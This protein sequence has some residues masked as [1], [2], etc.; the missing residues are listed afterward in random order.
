MKKQFS[1]LFGAFALT[2]ALI[3]NVEAKTTEAAKKANAKTITIGTTAGDFSELANVGLKPQLEKQGYTVKVVE[4]TDYE[5]PNIA[6][7][8]GKIDVN[9]FQHKPYLDEFIKEK[10]LHL[11]PL[12]QV[13]TAPLALYPAKL[14][15]LAEVKDGSTIAVPSDATN[16]SRALTILADLKWIE[17]NKGVN[18]LLVS[19]KDITKNPKNLKITS[20]EAS[21]IPTSLQTVDYAVINGNFATGAGIP[22]TTALAEE[23][24]NVYVNW[25]VVTE[26]TFN[27]KLSKDLQAVLSSA[28][29][30]KY[31]TARFKGYKFP[32][33]WTAN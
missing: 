32:E 10:G 9:I 21:Q 6:L 12:A 11:K 19:V 23:K 31:A 5:T 22:L 1:F 2:L 30:K 14:K 18:P 25:A 20:V 7:A 33:T 17:L 3:A 29:F 13:P 15:T 27:T 16:L 28:D 24:S 4:F 26:K 8:D